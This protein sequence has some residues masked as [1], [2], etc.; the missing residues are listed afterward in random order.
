MLDF[1]AGPPP[2]QSHATPS[3]A[4]VPIV[5]SAVLSPQDGGLILERSGNLALV[6]LGLHSRMEADMQHTVCL[7]FD[8]DTIS[9]WINNYKA[10]SPSKISRGEFGVVGARRLLDLLERYNIKATW[11]VPGHTADTYPQVVAEISERGHEIGHHGYCH[12]NP[13][14]LGESE[15]RRIL[16]KGMASLRNITGSAP[17]GYRSPA[18]DLSPFSVKLL[19]ENGFLY[20]SSLMG[21]DYSPYFCRSGDQFDLESAYRFGS[22]VNLVELPVSWDLDDFPAFEYVSLPNKLYPG[23]RAPDDVY[24]I[25]AGN[26][27]FMRREVPGGIFTLTMHPQVIG[28]GHRML[29]L[30]RLIE[31]MM[32]QPGVR[33]LRM[34]DCAGEWKGQQA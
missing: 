19:M 29:M 18:W 26:F 9:L 7:S 22:T 32:A 6:T 4:L 30:E 5:A 12:E 10:T 31:H 14:G 13:L 24:A 23:L 1:T 25:W 16:Q 27:D 21:N 28:R 34:G 8:F 15:E 33:F 11:F 20:D 2:R 3:P 17:L